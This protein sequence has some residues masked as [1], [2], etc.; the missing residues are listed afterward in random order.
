MEGRRVRRVVNRLPPSATR[1]CSRVS[2]MSSS[3]RIR[4][5][6][7]RRLNGI[8]LM[9][10]ICRRCTSPSRSPSRL[11]L[12]APYS[13]NPDRMILRPITSRGRVRTGKMP[14]SHLPQSYQSLPAEPLSRS[15]VCRITSLGGDAPVPSRTLPPTLHM[16][17][18]LITGRLRATLGVGIATS[19]MPSDRLRRAAVPSARRRTVGCPCRPSASRITCP[20]RNSLSL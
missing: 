14:A 1:V 3:G 6:S 7:V 18:T 13:P 9:T 5:S 17:G 12:K 19:C 8:K 2:S 16:L 10:S 4:R 20:P 11:T 15:L